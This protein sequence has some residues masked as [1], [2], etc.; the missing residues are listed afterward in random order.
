MKR[1][2]LVLAGI[3]LVCGLLFI[4]LLFR[5]NSAQQDERDWFVQQVRYEFSAVVD[6]VRM[7]NKH[8]GRLWCRVTSG[9]PKVHREDSLKRYFKEHDMLYLVIEQSGDTVT[10]LVP[11]ADLV[12]KE[13]S[14]SVSSRNNSIRFFRDDQKVADE[15]LS[16]TL[17]GFGKPFFLKRKDR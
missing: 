14:V 15:R 12:L 11:F 4:R 9:D 16:E 6:S 5:Q 10:F 2:L 1:N 7:L 13:D 17:T 3:A 8:T